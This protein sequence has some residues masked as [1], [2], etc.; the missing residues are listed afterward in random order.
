MSSISSMCCVA[1]PLM[2]AGLL[3]QSYVPQILA[4]RTDD[5]LA[6]AVNN[7]E[8]DTG[9]P[10]K[11]VQTSG[12]CKAWCMKQAVGFPVDVDKMQDLAN[13]KCGTRRGLKECKDCKGGGLTIP[14]CREQTMDQEET[15][16][17]I[18]QLVQ[19]TVAEAELEQVLDASVCGKGGDYTT[20]PC[21]FQ[22]GEVC[23][24]LTG[25]AWCPPPSRNAGFDFRSGSKPLCC[26]LEAESDMK[27]KATGV[28]G[29]Q[30]VQ[31]ALEQEAEEDAEEPEPTPPLPVCAVGETFVV[32]NMSM[33]RNKGTGQFA[34]KVCC[35]PKT[36]KMLED[37][38]KAED[39]CATVKSKYCKTKISVFDGERKNKYPAMPETFSCKRMYYCI[40]QGEE[41]F[42]PV[43]SQAWCL[44]AQTGLPKNRVARRECVAVANGV[45]MED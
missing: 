40:E 42:G 13:A 15:I 29:I 18:D 28:E 14:D 37:K 2:L 38:E 39:V 1:V 45:T 35:D 24:H 5:K 34:K 3:G 8:E 21:S 27:S 33:C 41:K 23:S 12:D 11:F 6:A 36:F 31:E 44:S 17:Q 19:E 25:V 16:A 9:K 22:V 30:A 20:Q 10:K 32:D 4:Y 43:P 7:Q 26:S